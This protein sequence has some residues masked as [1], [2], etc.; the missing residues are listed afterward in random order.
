M[1]QINLLNPVVGTNRLPQRKKFQPNWIEMGQVL[2][3]SLKSVLLIL[4]ILTIPASI[5]LGLPYLMYKAPEIGLLF[6]L[7]I[8]FLVLFLFLPVGLFFIF[9]V[10]AAKKLGVNWKELEWYKIV[11]VPSGHV[12][13]FYNNFMKYI[14][15]NPYK[16]YKVCKEGFTLLLFP[17][18]FEDRGLKKI[19]MNTYDGDKA[20]L[21]VNTQSGNKVTFNTQISWWIIEPRVFDRVMQKDDP[22][23]KIIE[24][25]HNYLAFFAKLLYDVDLTDGTIHQDPGSKGFKPDER[26]LLIAKQLVLSDKME[27]KEGLKDQNKIDV[28]DNVISKIEKQD[29]AKIQVDTG[30]EDFKKILMLATEL[31][32]NLLRVIFERVNGKGEKSLVI[33]RDDAGF[34]IDDSLAGKGTTLKTFSGMLNEKLAI[35]GIAAR[36]YNQEVVGDEKIE[37]GKAAIVAAN[38]KRQEAVQKVEA[39]KTLREQDIDPNLAFVMQGEGVSSGQG[40]AVYLTQMIS[41]A[42]KGRK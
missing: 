34:E 16:H 24:F 42:L 1:V 20:N 30:D 3:Q 18:L 22:V 29:P 17:F 38:L 32:A 14:V 31:K 15:D 33:E 39:I 9:G 19:T 35:L 36:I 12:H 27:E 25:E 11:E 10:Y 5:F 23:D 7:F 40:L 6:V 2:F 21:K 37:Q 26:A 8:I 28:I 13:L 41:N 4:A